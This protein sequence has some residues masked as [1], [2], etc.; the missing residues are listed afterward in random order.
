MISN[1]IMYLNKNRK[2]AGLLLGMPAAD[3]MAL[4]VMKECLPWGFCFFLK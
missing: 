1:K 4:P 2:K 3:N